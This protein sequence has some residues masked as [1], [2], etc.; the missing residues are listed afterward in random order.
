MQARVFLSLEF[1]NKNLKLLSKQTER[2]MMMSAN[3]SFSTR[4]HPEKERRILDR[5]ENRINSR[6]FIM[7]IS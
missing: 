1:F 4:F 6:L 7:K 3:S 2:L 5:E